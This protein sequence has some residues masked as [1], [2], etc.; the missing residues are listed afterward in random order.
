MLRSY[1][2]LVKR[3][4]DLN[5]RPLAR[6]SILCVGCGACEGVCLQNAIKFKLDSRDCIYKPVVDL[7]NC[8]WCMRCERVCPSNSENSTHMLDNSSVKNDNVQIFMGFSTSF[9]MRRNGASGGIITSL[10]L[11]MLNRK[12]VD[13]AIISKMDAKGRTKS[14]ATNSIDTILSAQGSIYFQTLTGKLIKEIMKSG[15]RYAIIG[16]PCQIRAIRKAEGI[17]PSFRRDKC[18]YLGLMCNHIN[19]SWYLEY[20]IKHV[21]REN[22]ENLVEISH[23]KGAWPGGIVL[24]TAHRSIYISLNEFW[25]GFPSLDFSCPI[26]CLFCEDHMNNSADISVGDAWIRKVMK[27]DKM[28]TSIIIA[29]SKRGLEVIEKAMEENV[30]ELVGASYEELLESQAIK[31]KMLK[32]SICRLIWQRSF[33]TAVENYGLSRTLIGV[34][35]LVH[36]LSGRNSFIRKLL[37]N[38]P[39]KLIAKYSHLWDILSPEIDR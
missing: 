34:L 11:H 18:I 39:R 25:K 38:C 8:S 26:G 35:P 7:N 37:I 1:C 9:S 24:R 17:F 27:R 2:S 31:R 6:F 21:F 22:H 10:L 23:R 28:G 33:T 4:C 5:E 20:I 19:A 32:A 30:V 15:K 13:A 36:S 12:L 3:I 29:R 16:L 14:F